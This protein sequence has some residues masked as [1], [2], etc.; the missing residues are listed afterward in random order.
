MN[1][2]LWMMLG[3]SK[4]ASVRADNKQVHFSYL[5]VDFNILK[6][7]NYIK[8]IGN[9]YL[10]MLRHLLFFKVKIKSS[11]LRFSHI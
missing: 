6:V 1:K 10:L 8:N 3:C 9:G 4:R 5:L 2:V 7:L 11:L